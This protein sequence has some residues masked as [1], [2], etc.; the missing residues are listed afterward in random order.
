MILKDLQAII[1]GN[2]T[3]IQWNDEA[4]DF[5]TL[6]STTHFVMMY[7]PEHL[8][9]REVVEIHADTNDTEQTFIHIELEEE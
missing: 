6:Y 4:E 5:T 3:L 8:Y 7:V 9:E 2:V 1:H